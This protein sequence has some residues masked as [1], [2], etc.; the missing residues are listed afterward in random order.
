MTVVP[1]NID[2]INVDM[3]SSFSDTSGFIV[4]VL[5]WQTED[6]YITSMVSSSSFS[7]L[8]LLFCLLQPF[9]EGTAFLLLAA[10]Q[11]CVGL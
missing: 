2:C 6:E 5:S 9:A 1:L 10:G 11:R 7:P 3:S 4:S 8:T